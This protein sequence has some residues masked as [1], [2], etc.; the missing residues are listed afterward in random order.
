MFLIGG[1]KAVVDISRDFLDTNGVKQRTDVEVKMPEG[2]P[3]FEK[4]CV[5]STLIESD[6]KQAWLNNLSSLNVA[7]Q[8]GLVERFDSTIGAGTVLMPFG[9][10]KQLTPPEAMAAKVPLIKGETKTATLMSFGFNPEISVWSPFHGAVYAVVESLAKIVA[11]GGKAEDIRLTF[12]E[13]FEKL[14][15][16]P[17]KWVS[18]LR[19]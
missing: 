5:D 18:L 12:Q 19:L 11:S 8:K 4:T 7:S 17:V 1:A 14:G 15:T 16:D 9:G 13:Y 10:K 3:Y 2:T 6:L